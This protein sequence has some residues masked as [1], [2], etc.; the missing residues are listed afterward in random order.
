[1]MKQSLK[2]L[3]KQYGTVLDVTAHS[4]VRMRGQAFVSMDSKEAAAK[5]VK[6]VKDFPLYGKPMVSLPFLLLGSS[7]GVKVSMDE[8]DIVFFFSN[9]LSQGLNRM[10]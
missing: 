4:N 9:W 1:V 10:P 5:A 3:F 6:E 2:T 8:A 7:C